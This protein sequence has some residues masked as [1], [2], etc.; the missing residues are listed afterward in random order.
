MNTEGTDGRCARPSFFGSGRA[1]A[2]KRKEFAKYV[3][4]APSDAADRNHSVCQFAL[5]NDCQDAEAIRNPD[6]INFVGKM[7]T[8]PERLAHTKG[9]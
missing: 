3:A 2:Y 5:S 1:R 8:G 9:K 4:H 7:R 6:K